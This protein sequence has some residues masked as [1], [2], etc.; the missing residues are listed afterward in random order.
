MG[1]ARDRVPAADIRTLARDYAMTQS[2]MIR[3]GGGHR[4]ARAWRADR[5]VHT[6]PDRA[7]PPG[8]SKPPSCSPRGSLQII[9][10]AGHLPHV[11]RPAQFVAALLTFLNP[12]GR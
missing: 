7:R 10:S 1:R 3:I 2:S 12:G 5:A 8:H 4:A 9:P 11:E 6:R